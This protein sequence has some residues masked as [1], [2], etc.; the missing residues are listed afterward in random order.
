MLLAKKKKDSIKIII[1]QIITYP[2][3]LKLFNKFH[4]S[5]F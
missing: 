2:L 1:D 4:L 3:K 5:N